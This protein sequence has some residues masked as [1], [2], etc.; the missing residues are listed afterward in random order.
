MLD[1]LLEIGIEEVPVTQILPAVERI[2]RELL[3][4]LQ[5]RGVAT[6]NL[7]TAA[8]NRRWMIHIEGVAE[9]AATREEK[10]LGP[11]KKIAIDES[12][13]P[14]KA[15]EKFLESNDVP[16]SQVVEIEAKKGT[17]LG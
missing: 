5:E 17:Y 13:H 8:T 11:A 7:E 6:G 4:R 10:V 1:L 14:T 16:L 9:H 15:L 2:G 3:S 12:G